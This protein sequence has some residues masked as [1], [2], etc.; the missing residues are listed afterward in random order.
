MG[1]R[2]VK[3]ISLVWRTERKKWRVEQSLRDL[4]NIKCMNICIMGNPEREKRKEQLRKQ[5]PK[6]F[7]T[8]CK[9]HIH[10]TEQTTNNP[11]P[12]PINYTYHKLLMVKDRVLEA[13]R[14]KQ[15]IVCNRF[16][17]RLTGHFALETTEARRQ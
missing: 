1:D 6:S 12:K 8:W 2:Q 9:I 13:T 10:K 14:T 7:Q 3:W 11:P 15:L 16:S 5:R 17:V 4:W